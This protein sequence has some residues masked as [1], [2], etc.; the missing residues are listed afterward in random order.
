MSD[1]PFRRFKERPT[2][3]FINET[4]DLILQTGLPELIP[5]LYHAPISKTEPY[6]K[7]CSF[8]IK[9]GKRPEGDYAPCPMCTPNRYLDGILAYFPR[10]QAVAAIGHCCADAQTR[11]TA[12]LES[13][14]REAKD[15]Q[16][17]LLLNELPI[18]HAKIAVAR[19]AK[20]IAQEARRIYRQFRSRGSAMHHVL[21]KTLRGRD[22]LLTIAESVASEAVGGCPEGC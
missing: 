3:I 7:L 1:T 22:G 21:K 9:D 19:A 6:Q 2:L 16:E 20:P 18:V 12:D 17:T 5:E 11:A 4:R 15:Y 14:R 10:L 8:R 13:D